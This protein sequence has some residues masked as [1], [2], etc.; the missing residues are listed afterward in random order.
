MEA[1]KCYVKLIKCYE[2]QLK[3]Q[4]VK[5]SISNLFPAHNIF[6][7]L[8]LLILVFVRYLKKDRDLKLS[9]TKSFNLDIQEKQTNARDN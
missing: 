9:Y 8:V 1:K 4:T 2:L 7:F 5:T 6:L 3:N